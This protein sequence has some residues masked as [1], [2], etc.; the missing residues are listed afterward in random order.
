MKARDD[1]RA[2][3][4][5]R[6]GWAEAEALRLAG[7]A[8]FRHYGRLVR[9]GESAVLM[10][11]PPGEEDVRP[12]VRMARVLAEWGFSP[13]S[14]LAADE[15]R[16]FVLLEDLGDD[17]FNE[18]LHRG[19]GEGELYE[20]AVDVLVDLQTRS[21]PHGLPRFDRR[22]ILAEVELFLDWALPAL[23][24]ADPSAAAASSFRAAWLEA[25]PFI[26]GCRQTTALFDY[27][28]DNLIWLPARRGIRRV[29][30]LDFQDAVLGPA[31]LDLVS[32]L[33]D[34][35]RDV[36][37]ALAE[38]MIE[39]Y[40]DASPAAERGKFRAAYAATGAQRNTRILGVFARLFLR[41]GK[42]SYLKMMPR[43]WRLLERDLAHPALGPVRQWFDGAVPRPLR[44][45]APDA[46]GFCLPT[47]KLASQ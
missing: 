41:D 24:G 20:A 12:F 47:A 40:L 5:A 37:P 11:A 30:L 4:L 7:D 9:A 32:L 44:E 38:A 42:P 8:S 2:D 45:A 26:V 22:R 13:P 27:H 23:T 28:A 29:G 14:I 46:A 33:E 35:R 3:F 15:E 6:A 10:D 25:V 19:G 17:L 16:G 34:A 39:R 31:A 21:P 1:A 36:P 43:V 18:V